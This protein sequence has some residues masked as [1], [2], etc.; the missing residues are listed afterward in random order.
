MGS[1]LHNSKSENIFRN[2]VLSVRA[3]TVDNF[4]NVI[5]VE[6]RLKEQFHGTIK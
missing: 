2:R 4:K 3:Y 5:N 6:K 1:K